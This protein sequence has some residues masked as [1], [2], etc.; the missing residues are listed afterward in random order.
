MEDL[1]VPWLF[2]GPTGS[3]KR[4]EA[5]ALL[6]A[7]HG[8][9]TPLAM[10]TRILPVGDG[11]E[12]RIFTSPY[13]FEIDIP[14]L[15]MQDKQIIGDLLTTFFSSTDVLHAL[16]SSA[17]KL[18]VLRRA[19]SLSLPAA[20]RVRAI[21]QQ[22]VF[23]PDAVG[24]IWMTAREL[25][26]PLTLLMDGFCVRRIPRMSFA[27]WCSTVSDS[28]KTEAAYDACEGR[29]ERA[30][31]LASLSPTTYP[32]R[33]QDYYDDLI[34]SILAHTRPSTLAVVSWARACVYQ[35]LSFCQTGPEIVDSCAAALER[36][37]L[38]KTSPLYQSA[39]LWPLMTHLT[40]AEPHTSYRT[41]LAL[42]MMLI[43]LYDLLKERAPTVPNASP[44]PVA[45]NTVT[46]TTGAATVPKRRPRRLKK[47]EVADPSSSLST[48]S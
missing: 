32:R 33:I 14:T 31:A 12:A 47:N 30:A 21:L 17:R 1:A 46:T 3:G 8:V 6:A 16:R 13:H 18:V 15:S 25:T 28:Y 38:N 2:L 11:Y 34:R 22:Y 5:H 36:A 4:R 27:A 20:V 37:V 19:H 39:A 23:P 24:M 45:T 40:L 26:G 35:M 29:I 42:E 7:A 41:P 10:D 43:G 48:T 9:S 44:T